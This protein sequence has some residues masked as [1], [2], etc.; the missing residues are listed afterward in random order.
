MRL[1]LNFKIRIRY[2]IQLTYTSKIKKKL[3]GKARL[4]FLWQA[5]LVWATFW[6]TSNVTNGRTVPKMMQ[7]NL[8]VLEYTVQE[9]IYNSILPDK[10]HFWCKNRK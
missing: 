10:W 9:K 6:M 2:A 8:L 4:F 1:E 3:G 7:T 5:S